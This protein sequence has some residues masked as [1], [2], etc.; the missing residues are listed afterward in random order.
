V[1]GGL[2]D[3]LYDE[4]TARRIDR[5]PRR[6]EVRQ[7]P[8]SRR[9]FGA[10]ALMTAVALGLQEVFDPRDDDEIILE[11]DLAGEP[12]DDQPVTLDYDPHSAA[13]SRAHVRPWLLAPT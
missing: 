3:E 13:R 7:A 9:A 12:H 8:R 2:P 1:D 6:R 5:S 10:G 11:V 4:A